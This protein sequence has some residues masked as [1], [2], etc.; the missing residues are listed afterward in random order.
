MLQMLK[1]TEFTSDFFSVIE[2]TTFLV[3]VPGEPLVI[4][5]GHGSRK[6]ST[7]H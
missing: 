6:K 5:L 2:K 4:L 1:K 7:V 3:C